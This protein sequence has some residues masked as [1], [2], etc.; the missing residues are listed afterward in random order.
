MK[1]IPKFDSWD[2]I[3]PG[4]SLEILFGWMDQNAWESVFSKKS[5]QMIL[6]NQVSAD[7]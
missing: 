2:F 3:K 7:L 6:I 4:F 5:P 1:M